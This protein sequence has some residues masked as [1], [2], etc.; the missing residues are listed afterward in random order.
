MGR[1]LIVVNMETSPIFLFGILILLVGTAAGKGKHPNNEH[2]GF[3]CDPEN[4]DKNNE[5]KDCPNNNQRCE[6]D[7]GDGHWYCS[8]EDQYSVPNEDG[9]CKLDICGR[10]GDDSDGDYQTIDGRCYYFE[11]VN[12]LD[13]VGA[14]ASCKTKFDGKGR[15]FEPRSKGSNTNVVGQAAG[16]GLDKALWIGIRTQPHIE[17]AHIN[18][19][20][21]SKGPGVVNLAKNLWTDGQPN[22]N[23][24]DKDCVAVLEF[25]GGNLKWS[26][27]KCTKEV[28]AIC[29]LNEE[30]SC[31]KPDHTTDVFCD[32]ENNNAGCE[33]DGGACCNRLATDNSFNKWNA[34]CK[35][36]E[37]IDPSARESPVICEDEHTAK[38]CKKCKGK[39]C[40]SS[41]DCKKNCK[42]TCKLC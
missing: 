38:K 6:D 33:W 5:N 18:F 17:G 29:E 8:C 15:L 2:K 1:P 35:D 34:F 25:G 16:L 39:K 11:K 14:V 7:D 40:K 13:F 24:G 41:A 19:Y 30:A 12:S 31:G 26:Q 20:Y 27:M 10:Y 32:D 37:C 9:F 21:I 3:P 36:C 42:K 22:D 23:S 4:N 28:F